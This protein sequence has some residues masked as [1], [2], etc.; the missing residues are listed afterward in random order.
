MSRILTGVQSTGTPHLGNLLGAILP[1]IEMANKPNNDSFIFIADM[2]SLTQIKDAETLRN[3]TYSVA[4]TWLACGIDIEKTVFYRQSDI[5][6]TAELSWYLSC[7][8][9]YQRLTL[10]H[11][12]KDKSDRLEDVN[13]GLFTYPMLMAAD[14]L[15]YDAEVVPVGKDQLQ[16]LEITRDVASRFHSKMGEAFVI[17]EAK[18]QENTMYVPGTDGAKMSK[19]KGNTI[20]LFVTDKKLRK[21]IMAID[22]DSTPLEEPKNP[23]TC[24]VFALYKLVATDAQIAEMRKNYEAGGFG[25][26]HAKQALYELLLEQFETP[27]KK[28]EYYM[29]NL[30]EIDKALEVGAEKARNVA[31]EVIKRVRKKVGY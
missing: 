17:P 6:Q 16:H 14:I 22:T 10:A 13:A 25:Y 31:N 11:S 18:V 1:A 20:N 28:Y 8:F 12:F 30:E 29:N 21:Q 3:N 4:A 9:P 26:G 2:H 5:P 27:R 19:S 15:L 23:D 24:N 7:F